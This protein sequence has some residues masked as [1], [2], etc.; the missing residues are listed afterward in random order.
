MRS[1][2]KALSMF[3]AAVMVISVSGITALATTPQDLQ[4]TPPACICIEKCT[5]G[6]G[7]PDCPVCGAE[8]ADLSLC[9][10]TPATTHPS[11]WHARY[12]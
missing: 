5:K 1:L 6:A 11:Q 8:G 12:H 2:R 4:P 3:L 9:T 7:D 10:G